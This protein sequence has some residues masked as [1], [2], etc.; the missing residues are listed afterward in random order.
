LSREIGEK[1]SARRDREEIGKGNLKV[2][3]IWL[4][5]QVETA[6]LVEIAETGSHL[7]AT[8]D[9]VLVRE[10]IIAN[11]ELRQVELQDLVLVLV[12]NFHA[13]LNG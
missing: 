3:F 2:N 11:A 9:A 8:V 10:R 4:S 6:S 13:L 7:L 5:V 1:E 12:P